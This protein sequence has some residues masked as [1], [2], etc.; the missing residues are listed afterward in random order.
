MIIHWDRYGAPSAISDRERE[1][2]LKIATPKS[3]RNLDLRDSQV[4]PAHEFITTPLAKAAAEKEK[5]NIK[6]RDETLLETGGLINALESNPLI[7]QMVRSIWLQIALSIVLIIVA[8]SWLVVL[9][10]EKPAKN[11]I[12]PA[13]SE[14]DLKGRVFTAPDGQKSLT[15]NK[16]GVGTAD[17]L[18]TVVRGDAALLRGNPINFWQVMPGSLLR[19]ELWYEINTDGVRDGQGTVLYEADAPETEVVSEMRNFAEFAQNY[20]REHDRSY[21]TSAPECQTFSDVY[22]NPFTHRGDAPNFSTVYCVARQQILAKLTDSASRVSLG[23]T[24]QP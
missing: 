8:G 23:L 24:R 19:Q 2:L 13:S 1:E 4:L 18:G 22:I 12:L 7:S 21:P 17:S 3:K 5:Q 16:V 20:Y 9:R 6:R 10:T 15:F 11:A 14:I